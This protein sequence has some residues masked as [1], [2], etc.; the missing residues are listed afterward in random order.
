[1]CHVESV[2]EY[3]NAGVFRELFGDCAIM[4]ADTDVPNVSFRFP[5]L[6]LI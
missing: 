3:V 1:M 2:H 4:G 5:L 6:K